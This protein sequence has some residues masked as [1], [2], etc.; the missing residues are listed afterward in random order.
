MALICFNYRIFRDD[1][2]S[3]RG[4]RPQRGLIPAGP[5]PRIFVLL[6]LP[7]NHRHPSDAASPLALVDV[8]QQAHVA[9]E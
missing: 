4:A 6:W 7:F 2:W 8:Q 9:A 3:S 5:G 1:L